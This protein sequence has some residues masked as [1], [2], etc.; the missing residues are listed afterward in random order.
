[1]DKQPPSTQHF[2]RVSLC[3]LKAGIKLVLPY[4]I[5]CIWVS[6]EISLLSLPQ[7]D[8]FDIFGWQFKEYL[9][10]LL[11]SAHLLDI[12]NTRSKL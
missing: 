8:Y 1:M 10:L 5:S 12:L 6:S 9:P 3:A 2:K 4:K 7:G 11:D